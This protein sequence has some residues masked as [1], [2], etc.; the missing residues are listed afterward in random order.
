MTWRP[1]RLAAAALGITLGAALTVAAAPARVV[2]INLCTDQLAMMLAAPGQLAS[3]SWLAADP[4]SS[5]MAAA[6]GGYRLNHAQA[7]QIFLMHPDLVLAGKYNAAATV[8]LLRRLGVTVVQ[9]APATSFADVRRN[10]LAVGAALGREAQAREMADRFDADLAALRVT[11][12]TP[13]PAALYYPSGYTPG[14]GTLADEILKLTGFRNIAAQAGVS[15]G[16]T[17]PLEKLVMARPRLI[18]TSAPYPGESRAEEILRHPALRDV[19]AQAMHVTSDADWVC[20][21]PKLLGAVAK[22]A[23]ARRALEGGK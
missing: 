7:E 5:A 14:A 21:T 20:G 17:L 6:A 3:V 15:G 1:I 23:Q 12:E 10:L 13:A 2:S 22:M 9:I 16:G 11:G 18:V 8:S 19:R 4:R